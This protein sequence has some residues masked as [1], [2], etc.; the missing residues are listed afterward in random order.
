MLLGGQVTKRRAAIQP[1]LLSSIHI[2]YLVLQT[3]LIPVEELLHTILNLNLVSP[4]EAM[5]LI[6]RDEL[7]WGSIWL[8]G[9]KLNLT[10]ETYSLHYKL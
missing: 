7:S 4:A 10:L 8:A 1:S 9:I 6:Y 2:W 5:K 3:F